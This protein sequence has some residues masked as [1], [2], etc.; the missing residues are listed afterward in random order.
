[1]SVNFALALLTALLLLPNAA[2]F[3][4]YRRFAFSSAVDRYTLVVRRETLL[5]HSRP[6]L[7]VNG[8]TPGPVHITTLGNE[9]QV[10]VINEVY[11]DAISIHWHGMSLRGTPQMDGE[12][13]ACIADFLIL[14]FPYESNAFVVNAGV[15]NVT[16]CPI[17]NVPGYNTFVYTFRPDLP[18]TYWYHGH[19]HSQY[20]D[21]E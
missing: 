19:M 2:T 15:V 4:I 12:F 16:Q 5:G 8:S 10:T 21:G 1:M 20:P 17:S 9:L 11:D 3:T 7:T 18:G 6:Q 13:A 14:F